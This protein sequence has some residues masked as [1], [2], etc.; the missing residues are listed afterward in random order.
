MTPAT[1]AGRT[2]QAI[3]RSAAIRL[4][5]YRL[6]PNRTAPPS[7]RSAVTLRAD[8]WRRVRVRVGRPTFDRG[9]DDA[10]G[11]Q[12]ED[13]DRRARD[14]VAGEDR[15]RR[16]DRPLGRNDRPD[17]AD[18]AAPQRGVDEQQPTGVRDARGREVDDLVLR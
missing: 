5:A 12:G 3:G 16:T 14:R 6:I 4:V 1:R 17:D 2:A 8:R 9:E 15:E 18:L 13:R 10:G 11:D 7:A